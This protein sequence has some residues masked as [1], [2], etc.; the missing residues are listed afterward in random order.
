RA[1]RF[2]TENRGVK[3]VSTSNF[4]NSQKQ[5]VVWW[6]KRIED[7]Y[8]RRFTQA[9]FLP[10]KADTI[11]RRELIWAVRE[12]IRRCKGS[13]HPVVLQGP[14][15]V[16][17]STLLEIVASDAGVQK[18]FPHGARPILLGAEMTLPG[19][20]G[21]VG[22]VLLP[23][24]EGAGRGTSPEL[25]RQLAAG[26]QMV[27]LLDDCCQAEHARLVASLASP[28]S[29]VIVATRL[30]G[31]ARSLSP[32]QDYVIDVGGFSAEEVERYYQHVWNNRPGE[33]DL[34]ELATVWELM[35]GNPLG[36]R[37]ALHHVAQYG[38]KTVS[39]A[40]REL[41]L[42]TPEGIADE[43]Y[44][45]LYLAY[46]MLSPEEQACFRRLGVLPELH[47]YNLVTFAGLWEREP[48]HALRF[49][50][51]LQ[52]DAGLVQSIQD[53]APLGNGV[54]LGNRAPL[55]NG[56]RIAWTIHQQV[57]N[58]ARSLFAQLPAGEQRTARR[59]VER[60]LA[61]PE[62]QQRHDEFLKSAPHQPVLAGMIKEYRIKRPYVGPL[63]VIWLRGFWRLFNPSYVP[64]WPVFESFRAVLTADEYL[65]ISR[66]VREERNRNRIISAY[67]I[68]LGVFCCFWV[69]ACWL[70]WPLQL[71]KNVTDVIWA[72]AILLGLWWGR[73]AWL[74][75]RRTNDAWIW[76]WEEMARR[77][78]AQGTAPGR[79]NGD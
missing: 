21:A 56:G 76:L 16:G 31:V 77:I 5:G 6:L 43:L 1:G 38:W 79:K 22:Q 63:P 52:N 32:S 18:E 67:T 45:P 58:Y 20:L 17:K 36:I 33:Q 19:V 37:I 50:D 59:W 41:P 14:P 54:P 48:A 15:G 23:G 61:I 49:L 35:R 26:K 10:R 47:S 4:N 7:E 8:T 66:I 62:Q 65:V 51:K 73:V 71:A 34:A 11:D 12:R 74:S 68:A 40:L 46:T 60:A 29:L 55:G 13:G 72:I 42:P 70:R 2:W 69:L 53:R 24:A 64:D 30:S 9:R 27:F 78:E 39:D 57:M 44:R 75:A 28:D 3:E 25:L